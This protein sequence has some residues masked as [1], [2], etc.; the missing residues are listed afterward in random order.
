M[1]FWAWTSTLIFLCFNRCSVKVK[2]L[3]SNTS[4][5]SQW[6]HQHLRTVLKVRA[7]L[8]WKLTCRL[9]LSQITSKLRQLRSERRSMRTFGKWL[10]SVHVVKPV[11]EVHL[12]R[13]FDVFAKEPT[14]SSITSDVPIKRNQC[15]MI[16]S[17]VAMF[18]HVQLIGR[19]KNG[20]PVIVD[21][22]TSTN[23]KL[24][25]SNVF[26]SYLRAL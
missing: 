25:I 3:E 23:I 26:K 17:Y 14:N 4:I 24:E 22:Q 2:I 21:C 19:S 15:W 8:K 5:L 16:A 18:N 9:I 6:I 12:L 13:S 11:V 7:A 1:E 20:R 10:A